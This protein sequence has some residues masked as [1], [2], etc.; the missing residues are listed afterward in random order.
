MTRELDQK[1]RI[2]ATLHRALKETMDRP[3]LLL[4]DESQPLGYTER[5]WLCIAV[6]AGI[7]S[8]GKAREIAREPIDR[9]R[10]RWRTF[11]E[12]VTALTEAATPEEEEGPRPSHPAPA[13]A[14]AS[15]CG[16]GASG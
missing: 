16:T 14:T 6:H 9:W 11:G 8:D 10:D 15:R 1:T 7:I 3:S 13:P 2:I 12:C 4:R 5:A